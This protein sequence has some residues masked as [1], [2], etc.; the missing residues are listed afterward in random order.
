MESLAVHAFLQRALADA[1]AGGLA[2]LEE[3]L[4]AFPGNDAAITREYEALTSR[5]KQSAE[6]S[7]DPVRAL[8]RRVADAADRVT[9]QVA[10][11][12]P[13]R[14]LRELGRGGQGRVLLAED[15]RLGRKVAIKV[16][17]LGAGS[18]ELARLRR[19]GEIAA[20]IDDPHVC[21]V[22]EVGEVE[23]AAFVAMQFVEG[24]TL[25]SRIAETARGV[26]TLRDGD[27]DGSKADAVLRFIERIARSL[28][29]MHSSGIVHRDLKPA[30][31]MVMPDGSP[32]ILDLGLARGDGAD[33][34]ALTR[35]GDQLGTPA[36]MAPEQLGDVLIADA[37][38]DVWALGVVLWE[39]L[40]CRRPFDAVTRDGLV[41]AIRDGEP[42]R[43][44]REFAAATPELE[45]VLETAISPSR[46]G[47]YDS[48]L[49]FADDVGRL[50]RH[51]SVAARRSGPVRRA[52]RFAQRRPSAVAI[53][54]LSLALAIG[55]PTAIAI[56]AHAGEHR[57]RVQRDRADKRT[58]DALDAIRGM[59]VEVGSDDLS[60]IEEVVEVRRALLRR[61]QEMLAKIVTAGEDPADLSRDLLNIEAQLGNLSR[62]TQD[63]EIARQLLESALARHDQLGD[64]GEASDAPTRFMLHSYLVEVMSSLGDA[65][66]AQHHAEA[67]DARTEEAANPYEVLVHATRYWE[68]AR[69]HAEI[70]NDRPKQGL[71]AAMDAMPRTGP[72]NWRREL[73]Q[74]EFSL[75]FDRVEDDHDSEALEEIEAIIGATNDEAL[76][77]DD[78]NTLLLRSD[79]LWAVGRELMYREDAAAAYPRLNEAQRILANLVDRFPHHR[80]FGPA[81][82]KNLGLLTRAAHDQG[83]DKARDEWISEI[84][85]EIE[86]ILA[87]GSIDAFRSAKI[88][89]FDAA[90]CFNNRDPTRC[91]EILEFAYRV[92]LELEK[93]FPH[94]RGLL[95]D[96][97][98]LRR[99]MAN[100]D[101][102][103]GNTERARS[104]YRE[105][106]SIYDRLLAFDVR[107]RAIRGKL[108]TLEN[109]ATVAYQAGDVALEAATARR[110]IELAEG[111]QLGEVNLEQSDRSWLINAAQRL[112]FGLT[113]HQLEAGEIG[114]AIEAARTW[115]GTFP[116]MAE[117]LHSF[118]ES[119]AWQNHLTPA[120]TDVI[121][122]RHRPDA[123]ELIKLIRLL[124]GFHAQLGAR[125]NLD[126]DSR[127][128][129]EARVVALASGLR[130]ALAATGHTPTPPLAED[131]E[132]QTLPRS[133]LEAGR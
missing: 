79:A 119:R 80:Q 104:L 103:A 18:A 67:A 22:F 132:L 81:R 74:A 50:I 8:A 55:I 49:A 123:P 63:Y 12:G 32:M 28:H 48:A 116:R 113:F 9:P 58:H 64:H 27:T 94:Y 16:L 124:G 52:L 36:Y 77:P 101:L 78:V 84:R 35:T 17:P 96:D 21:T 44:R 121:L 85:R 62:R 56:E 24:Q 13:Y 72:V 23:G 89:V 126:A 66:A 111:W 114:V 57:V 51:E 109:L 127:E 33:L 117:R 46:A 91:R 70:D 25:A 3:Y 99:G 37:Q 69:R 125:P 65:A 71:V 115:Q 4:A 6:A 53:G 59:L 38:T 88:A 45:A 133:V 15:S 2:T 98:D 131:P 61:A 26:V 83:L 106:E 14:I 92:F 108:Q 11:I 29:V 1:A 40:T 90:Q 95:W 30:N 107:A 118:N 120:L 129:I 130:R 73:L 75:A 100:L 43:L 20:R 110:A 105:A 41:A 31:I 76:D 128:K 47:R 87:T 102:A 5:S 19:E 7:E 34:V 86:P 97:A 54:G 60:G 93:R 42:P 39:C 112:S 68:A 10:S 82:L 122:Q